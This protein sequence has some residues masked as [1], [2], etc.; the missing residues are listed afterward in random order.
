MVQYVKRQ[1]SA[2]MVAKQH[3]RL[4][5][6]RIRNKEYS[7]LRDMVPSIAKKDKISKVTVIE[8]AVKYIDEL[9]RALFERLHSK[10]LGNKPMSDDHVKDFIHTL[11][12]A[13]LFSKTQSSSSTFEKT[14]RHPS[15]LMPKK[16][17][18]FGKPH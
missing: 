4:H 13:D 1:T 7:R 8:E 11:I 5:L 3:L 2:Q 15:Y 14:Q 9:H 12:P 18:G 17:R 16:Q 10:A 6:R